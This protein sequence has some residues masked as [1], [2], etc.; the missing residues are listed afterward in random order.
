MHYGMTITV[1]REN[2]V[3]LV[4]YVIG[5]PYILVGVPKCSRPPQMGGTGIPSSLPS[6]EGSDSEEHRSG[7]KCLF[8][9]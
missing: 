6:Q 2:L 1:C 7:A 3:C 9:G 5:A 4:G 8:L